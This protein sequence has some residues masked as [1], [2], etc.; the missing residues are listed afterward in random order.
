[1]SQTTNGKRVVISTFG[2]FGDIHPYVAVALELRRR[3]HR[4]VLATSAIYRQKTDAL[5]LELHPVRPDLPPPDD[6]EATRRL[7]ADLMDETFAGL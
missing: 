6:S 3:G 7:V 2:S 1:M 5:G 4:P